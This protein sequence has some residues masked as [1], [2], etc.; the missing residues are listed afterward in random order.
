MQY[1]SLFCC[2]LTNLS[3]LLWFWIIYNFQN[4]FQ[5]IPCI[6]GI[7]VEI[8]FTSLSVYRFNHLSVSVSYHTALRNHV[9][10]HLHLCQK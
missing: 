2:T 10:H 6:K 7:D 1:M 9:G 8:S 5:L 3:C 4:S